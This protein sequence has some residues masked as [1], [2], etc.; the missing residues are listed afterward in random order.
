MR[1]K[2]KTFGEWERLDHVKQPFYSWQCI[3]IYLDYKTLD[4]VIEDED[5]LFA[6]INFINFSLTVRI[7][8]LI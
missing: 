4:F 1:L 7:A 2:T 5:H 3:S 6:F 8:S